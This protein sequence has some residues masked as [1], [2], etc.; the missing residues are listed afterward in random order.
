MKL[1]I[2][3]MGEKLASRGAKTVIANVVGSQMI[4]D[5]LARV[6]VSTTPSRDTRLTLDAITA[7]FGNKARAVPESFRFVEG[8]SSLAK[9][10]YLGYVTANSEVRDFEEDDVVEESELEDMEEDEAVEAR[11]VE[12]ASNVVM[13]SEDQS[14][15]DVK[16][17]AGRKV[18]CRQSSEDLSTLTALASVRDV[19]APRMTT[20]ATT[21]SRPGEF[22]AYVDRNG[23]VKYGIILATSDGS[24]VDMEVEAEGE[25]ELELENVVESGD[26]EFE[27][28]PQLSQILDTD[29]NMVDTV[30]SAAIFEIASLDGFEEYEDIVTAADAA[31]HKVPPAGAPL[32]DMT[33][34]Y[35]GLYGWAPEFWGKLSGI[36]Q[37]HGF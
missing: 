31:N 4:N 3:R 6:L 29:T 7:A 32:T 28:D 25:E 24:D 30:E 34:Y 17:V 22:A 1:N 16:E 27:I 20:F 36:I 35:K 5:N 8:P 14:I 21:F 13:D 26:D 10:Y 15:W 23:I 18:L 9:H 11:Y 33:D 12:V 37:Q 19:Q 2:N